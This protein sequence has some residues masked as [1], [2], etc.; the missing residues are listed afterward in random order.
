M[1]SE[2]DKAPTVSATN[3]D[4]ECVELTY[5]GDDS[6][7]QKIDPSKGDLLAFVRAAQGNPRYRKA[8]V[9]GEWWSDE[10]E[11]RQAYI[12][13][14]WTDTEGFLNRKG[15]AILIQRENPGLQAGRESRQRR[16]FFIRSPRLHT[17]PRRHDRPHVGTIGQSRDSVAGPRQV[18]PCCRRSADTDTKQPGTSESPSG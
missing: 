4:A 12:D 13:E 2:G 10:A 16:G 8:F 3:Q 14:G 6:D 5:E 11:F 9:E 7:G 1:L 18:F 15:V 17:Q